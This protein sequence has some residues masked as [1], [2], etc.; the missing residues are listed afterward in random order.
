MPYYKTCPDCGA[1]LDPDEQCDCQMDEGKS[2]SNCEYENDKAGCPPFCGD[3][4]LCYSAWKP[5]K[6]KTA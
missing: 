2:C 5:K 4:G 1:H 3:D 6:R